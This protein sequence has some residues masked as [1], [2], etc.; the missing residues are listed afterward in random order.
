MPNRITNLFRRAT[1]FL[2][3]KPVPVEG[4]AVVQ[5]KPTVPSFDRAKDKLFQVDLDGAKRRFAPSFENKT[6]RGNPIQR[7]IEVYSRKE[8][9][10]AKAL[11]ETDFSKELPRELIETLSQK[12]VG[13]LIAIRE[14]EKQKTMVASELQRAGRR[15]KYLTEALNSKSSAEFEEW[16]VR[17]YRDEPQ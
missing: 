3:K 15:V 4:S 7:L 8:R 11:Q 9:V 10:L 17:I 16:L 12:A 5:E 6:I 1:G 14:P 13:S 2:R